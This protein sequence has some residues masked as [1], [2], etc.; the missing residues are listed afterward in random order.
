MEGVKLARYG[1]SPADFAANSVTHIEMHPSVILGV[2]ANQIIFPSNNQFPRD[3]FSCGQSKQAVSLY[4]SNYQNR[5]DKS[6]IVLN[7]GQT[8]LVKSRYLQHITREQHPYG[9][10]A[11]VAV[12]CYTGYNVE[13]AV[14]FNKASLDRGIFGTQYLNVYE[15]HEEE[16]KV[17]NFTVNTMFMDVNQ[18]NV[19]GLKPGYDYSHLDPESGLIR[20]H[21]IVDD[22]TILMGMASNSLTSSEVFIDASIG[23]KKGQLGYVDKAFMTIDEA[24]RKLAKVRIRHLRIPAIGDKFCSRVGQKGTIGIVLEEADMPFT[25][26]GMRPD[27]IVNPH[28]F[29]SRMTI[30]HL[31]ETLIGKAGALYGNFGDCTAFINRGPK[32][33]TFGALL[34]RAGFNSTGNEIMYNGMNGVQLETEIYFGPTFYLRL[35][36]MV[37]DKLNYR[38]RGPRTVLTRQTV[39]GRANNGG[40]RIGEMDRDAIVSHGMAGFLAESMMVRGDEFFMA[41]CNKTGTIAIYNASRDLF[42]SPMA[43]GPVKFVGNLEDELS[44]VPISRFGREFSI[45]RVPFA[46]KLLYQEL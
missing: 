40:L 42:L 45:V 43:D 4:N 10:N 2:M 32:N 33:R 5:M 17:G 9:V 26:E 29:P 24:G 7:Y 31:V 28:A 14:I 27:L 13:D 20:E 38:A 44:I 6:A 41:I 12:A 16:T 22:K 30:G 18:G 1:E 25:A 39:Q 15:A 36:H 8:P 23:C 11:I 3:L 46:F 19:I 21:T 34:T 35:K 37:K